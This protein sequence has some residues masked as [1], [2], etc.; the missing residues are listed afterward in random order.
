MVLT[1]KS[2]RPGMNCSLDVFYEQKDGF[3][4]YLNDKTT[5]K[6]ILLRSGSFIVED[7]GKYISIGTPALIFIN[8]KAEFKVVSENDI[9]TRTVY[10]SPTVI[11]DEFTIEALNSGKY[12]RFLNA[13]DDSDMTQ[14]EKMEKL[15]NDDIR[16]EDDFSNE[17]IYQDALYLQQFFMKDRDIGYFNLTLQ[18]YN[19]FMRVFISIEYE[20]KEQPDNF[21]IMRIRYFILQLLFTTSAD[22]Y[23]NNRQDDIYKDPLVAKVTRYLWDNIYEDITMDTV[24]KEFSINKNTLNDAFNKEV[25][26]SCMTYLEQMRINLAKHELRFGTHTISEIS[27]GCGYRET[28]YFTKVFKKYTGMTPSEYQKQMKSLDDLRTKERTFDED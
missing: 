2:K 23:R 11:R 8:D 28:N 26:M 6:M 20:V 3:S 18:E 4:D 5:Y 15:I 17:M 21:W 16:F 7:R 12:D 24:L 1:T 19:W 22:F 13:I 9:K 10:F 25:S 14:N 27:D